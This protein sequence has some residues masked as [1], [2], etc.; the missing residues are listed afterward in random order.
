[1]T[2]S[3]YR[4]T[5]DSISVTKEE[6]IMKAKQM[7]AQS[8]TAVQQPIIKRRKTAWIAAGAAAAVLAGTTLSVGAAVDWDYRSLFDKYFAEQAP[9]AE[10]VMYVDLTGMGADINETVEF[11][12]FTLNVKSVIADE[13]TLYALYDIT[14]HDDPAFDGEIY[15]IV[16]LFDVRAQNADGRCIL[17]GTRDSLGT[18]DEGVYRFVSRGTVSNS[19]TDTLTDAAITISL[20][21]VNVI[22][23][24]VKVLDA[25]Y[26]RQL[27][28]AFISDSMTITKAV[29]FEIP[30]YEPNRASSVSI[31]PF[32]LH[33]AAD[34]IK[35]DTKLNLDKRQEM[36]W[37][38]V[39]N[40][41][42]RDVDDWV[43]KAIYKD[44]TEQLL[45]GDITV[46]AKKYAD[47]GEYY[48]ADYVIAPDYPVN[49]NEIT[50][51]SINDII[52]PLA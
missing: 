29:D 1:M 24:E 19:R 44:G 2:M 36:I 22:G 39:G 45:S 23:D 7:Y 34:E 37:E 14:L 25:D 5:L 9:E 40:D 52:I 30:Y 10:P 12:D 33:L 27:D 50:A 38:I 28:S 4:K 35:D 20:H 8:E 15:D 21:G 49:T 11:E 13:Y 6:K 47:S 51:I 16:P 43:I 32:A 3:E 26:T 18:T 46:T 42:Y 17:D 31:S 48:G 41:E